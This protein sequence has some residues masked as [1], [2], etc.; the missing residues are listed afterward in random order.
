[1]IVMVKDYCSKHYGEDLSL[2]EIS[3]YVN[4]S[5]NYFCNYFKKNTGENFVQYLRKLRIEIAMRKLREGNEKIG[6]VAQEVG[7]RN[8]SHF[9]K[10]FKEETGM[11]PA[12][13]RSRKY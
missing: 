6:D 10:V 11:N 1:M 2:D 3:D 9:S 7:Y 8:V 12:E 13:Y 4:M 5:K